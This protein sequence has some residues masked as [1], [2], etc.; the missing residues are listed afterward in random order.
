MYKLRILSQE[1][2][3]QV[4]DLSTVIAD[5][6]KVYTMKAHQK[7]QLFPMVFHEFNPGVADMDIKSGALEEAGI[8]GLKVVSWFGENA[9]KGLPLLSGTVL[10]YDIHTGVPIGILS[11]EHLTAMRTGAAGAIG[12]KIL[13]KKSSKNLL[14]IGAGHQ[15]PY[16]IAA[17]LLVLPEIKTVR[18]FDPKDENNAK[19]LVSEIRSKLDEFFHVPYH[20]DLSFQTVDDLQDATGDSDIIITVTPARQPIIM[21]DWVKEGTHFS[22]VGADMSGKQEIDGSIFADAKIFVD[23]YIQAINVGECEIPLKEG[24]ISEDSI[25]G[26]IG[27]VINGTKTGR[28]NDKEIT[29]FD[30][31]G[32]ALQDLMVSSSALKVAEE[33]NIGTVVEL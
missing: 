16:Q 9:A 13:A 28:T 25:I 2:T 26:E 18:V 33:K 6:E 5:I 32:I 20:P 21:K 12:A 31:T 22:C 23:D 15:A 17:T 8:W 29:I 14:I 27:E 10:V 1:H 24:I 11:A 3:E 19:K 4:L 7:G 30:S